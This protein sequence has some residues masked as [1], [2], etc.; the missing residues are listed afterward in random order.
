MYDLNAF[1]FI[2][3]C[4]VAYHMVYLGEYSMCN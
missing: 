4:F 3:A 2:E 1:K